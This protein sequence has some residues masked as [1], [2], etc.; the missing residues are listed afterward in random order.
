MRN[1]IIFTILTV[2]FAAGFFVLKDFIPFSFYVIQS[3]SMAPAVNIG[4]LIMVGREEGYFTGDVVTFRD[5]GGRVVTHRIEKKD[6]TENSTQFWTKGD[7][8]PAG[9]REAIKADQIIGK[10]RLIIPGIGKLLVLMRSSNIFP[11]IF[12][13]AL[14][15]LILAEIYDV[16]KK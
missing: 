6:E 7:A 1:S 16:F 9:D 8:S 5:S 3:G 2:G 13:A 10:V 15:I 14:A 4:D 12:L 11:A